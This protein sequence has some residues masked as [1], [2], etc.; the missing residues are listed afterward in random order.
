[1]KDFYKNKKVLVTGHT[2]F[3]GSWLTLWLNDMGADITGFS[4][5]PPSEPYLYKYLGLKDEINDIKG[6]IRQLDTITKAVKESE[7]EIIFHLAGQP[8]LLRSYDDPVGTYST[9]V[10]GTLNIL[11]AI[12]KTGKT[13]TIVCITSD[14]VYENLQWEF[15]YRENDKLGGH[16]PYS[17]SKAGAELVARAYRESFLS[18]IGLATARAGNIIGGGDWG[19][20]R[21]VPDLVTSFQK[22][23]KIM[24]RDINGVRPWTYVLDVV[25]GYLTLAER[26]NKEPKGYSEAWNFSSNYVKTVMD[27]V[28]ELS[29]YYKVNYETQKEKKYE[30]KRLLLD[31]TK[32]KMRLGWHPAMDF[33]EAVKSTA[34][35]YSNFYKN[36]KNTLEYS[37]E[38]LHQFEKKIS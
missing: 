16:D 11:E 21:L 18:D 6:D 36:S 10:M 20:Y 25:H 7:P 29:K 32:S 35:W 22:G 30:D 1:M 37:K 31:S 23:S 24:L 2:G 5:N 13:K 15:A 34:L 27:V 28:T 8:I 4:L 26:L 3:V 38:Q 12:R 17:S 14:K 33:S 9:N 19:E